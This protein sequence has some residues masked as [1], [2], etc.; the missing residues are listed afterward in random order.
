MYLPAALMHSDDSD[1]FTTTPAPARQTSSTPP[2]FLRD[3]AY[4]DSAR[5]VFTERMRT[6]MASE[7]SVAKS[8]ARDFAE[9]VH[10]LSLQP[11]TV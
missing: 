1:P 4:P 11:G 7:R 5:V 8:L 9:Y 10:L 2:I 3:F 6:R